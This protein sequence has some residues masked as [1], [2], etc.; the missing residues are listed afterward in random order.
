MLKTLFI[1]SMSAAAI[2][3]K[4][5]EVLTNLEGVALDRASYNKVSHLDTNYDK[6]V[7][8]KD[9]INKKLYDVL[10]DN[11]IDIVFICGLAYKIPAYLLKIP[12]TTFLNIHFGKLPENR[13]AD[14]VFWTLKNGDMETAISVH[15]IDENW[16]TGKLLFK[17]NLSVILG[18]TY[19][20]LYSK[21]VLQTQGFVK[22]ILDKVGK[23]SQYAEQSI[24]NVN[25]NPKP[26][27][28]KLFIDW[29]NQTADDIEFLV[30]AC[31]PRYSGAG[32]YYEGGEVRILEVAQ[33]SG[34]EP[35][36]GRISGEII[37][38]H[39]YEGLFV[40]CKDGKLLK[41]NV[42]NSDAGL[43]SGV[44]YV[45]LGMCLG[46]RFTTHISKVKEHVI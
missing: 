44:K 6:H 5:L 46:Q 35:M 29:E 45:N 16:D 3:I 25:Y 18:E 4:E 40:V 9:F 30:N 22:E 17:K 37:H 1:G 15:K 19:G 20:M 24:E 38:A 42:L 8:S 34:Q 31:N 43:L 14:P 28:E 10:L 27:G 13:G 36:L 23:Y 12:N 39:P 41:I 11:E 26:V 7:V 21:L 32:T 33:V 2:L